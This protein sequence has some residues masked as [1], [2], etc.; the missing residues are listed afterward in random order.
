MLLLRSEVDESTSAN[1]QSKGVFTN[2]LK[3]NLLFL[4]SLLFSLLGCSQRR[5]AQNEAGTPDKSVTAH[6]VSIEP[7]AEV[8]DDIQGCSCYFSTSEDDLEADRYVFVDDLDKVA[9][10]NIDGTLTR[11]VQKEARQTENHHTIRYASGDYELT[12]E[13]IDGQPTGEEVWECTGTLTLKAKTEIVASR[14]FVGECGC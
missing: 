14:S 12:V 8:P 1:S 4:T 2:S 3:L 7:L 5:Q 11:F 9:Y 6:A 10:I 13:R